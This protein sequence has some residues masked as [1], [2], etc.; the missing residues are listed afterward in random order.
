MKRNKLNERQELQE[1]LFKKYPKLF[2]Q[3]NLPPSQT[4]M[5]WGIECGKGWFP[6]IEALCEWLDW[7]IKH[8]DYPQVEFIQI[9][10]KFGGLR[11]YYT[12]VGKEL[13]EKEFNRRKKIK[14]KY[15]DYK[16]YKEYYNIHFYKIDGAIE[17]AGRISY[18][19]CENCGRPGKLI[20]IYGWNYTLCKD[21]AK[22]V[23]DS[24]KE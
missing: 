6:I 8:N 3:V 7:N 5:C 9:K 22:Q 17:F 10:E 4:C 15:K 1:R 14:N 24:F 18:K 20:T 19:I 13:S 11:I 16:T 2:R 21:C 23:K 12:I